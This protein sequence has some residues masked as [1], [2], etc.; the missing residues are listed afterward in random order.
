MDNF[1]KPLNAIKPP[2]KLLKRE[3]RKDVMKQ[4]KKVSIEILKIHLRMRLV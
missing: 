1:L 4:L 3:K 2:L